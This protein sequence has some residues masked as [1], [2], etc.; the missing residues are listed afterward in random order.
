MNIRKFQQQLK[1]MAAATALSLLATQAIAG[2]LAISDTPLFLTTGVKPNLIM[3]IDDSGS[4]DF[5]V[6]LRGN[7]GAAWWRTGNSSG[8]CSSVT[9]NSFIG[10]IGDG[11]TDIEAAGQLNFNNKG[12]A[13]DTWK[14]FAYL[15]PNGSGGDTSDRRRNG[16]ATN[17]H[18]AIPPLG[19]FAWSRSPEYNRAYFD[20][21]ITYSRW[22]DGGGFTFTN[23]DPTAARFDPVFTGAGTLDLTQDVAGNGNV[24]LDAA[25]ADATM[26]GNAGNHYFKVFQGMTLPEGTC[27]YP[28]TYLDASNTTRNFNSSYQHWQVVSASGCVVGETDKCVAYINGAATTT[29]YTLNTNALVAIRYFPATF[30]LST[31]DAPEAFGYASTTVPDGKAPDGSTMY[32]YEIK[33]GNFVDTE[34]YTAALQNFANW[35]SYYRKRHQA[36]R[37]GLGSAFATLTGTR[38]AGFTIN[39]TRS[40]GSPDVT[41]GDIDVAANRTALY[42]NFYQNWVHSGGT[43]N[44]P[45]VANLIRNYQRTGAGAPIINSCQRNFG[46]LFT[47]GFSNPPSSGDG[48]KGGGG[49]VGN[50]DGSMADPY[51][52]SVDNT[53]ADGVM[54]GYASSLRP[55]LTQGKVT[56]PTACKDANHDPRL[57]CNT[58]PHMNFY[59]ITLGAKGLQFNPD[60]VPAQDPYANPPTWPTSFPQRHPSA[61]DD[62]WHATINGRGQLLNAKSSAELADK[63][64]A[65]LRSIADAVG[66]A[67][68][69]SVNSGS[70]NSDTRLFQASFDSRDWSGKLEAFQ[71]L[72]NGTLGAVTQATIP[73]AGRR[74]IITMNSDGRTVPFLWDRLDP[75]RQA[76]LDATATATSGADLVNYLRGDQSKET[77]AGGPYRARKTTVLG[78]IVNSSP[79]F[80]GAQNFRYP[81]TLEAAKYTDFRRTKLAR[82]H[83]VYVGANDG[84]LHAF[85]SDDATTTADG[86]P[87]NDRPVTETFAY[88]PSVVL[89]NMKALSDPSYTHRF[90]VDGTPTTGDA[91]VGNQW[92][93]MLAAGLNKGGQAIYALDITDA[94]AITETGANSVLHW[95]FTDASDPDHD[96]GFTYSRPQIVRLKTGKW[97]AIFGNGYNNTFADGAAS[98]TGNAVLYIVDLETGSLIRKID[99][100]AGTA[101]DPAGQG[102]PNGL[103][104]PVIVDDD[105]DSNADFVY[106]GDLFGNLWKFNIASADSSGWKISYGT[107]AAP[108]PIFVA[109]DA[110]GVRQPITSRPN[111]S[112]GPDGHGL[113]VLF[114]TGKY[115]ETG[116]GNVPSPARPQSFYGLI[117]PNTG[118]A[119]QDI[120]D[121][122]SKL[123]Q[124]TIASEVLD[125][126]FASPTGTVKADVRVTSANLLTPDSRGWYIDLVSPRVGFEGEM[127]V[128]DS[129]LRN[130]HVIFTTLIPNSDPCEN[131]GTSWL[132]DMNLFTGSRFAESPIDVNN[133]TKFTETL[134]GVPITGVRSK[135]GIEPKGGMVSSENCDYI[136]FPGTSGGTETRCRN[137]G[138]RGYGRQSWRQSR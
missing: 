46:M 67:A 73:S 99:T 41:M 58:D 39:Q 51:K 23:A 66:S 56:V 14:K 90:Y 53:L 132:M 107:A 89:K 109:K 119:T 65:V 80:V 52:D 106:A 45:A 15:F 44:R 100:K 54:S 4:M 97:A 124:Q 111:V 98:T 101:Q 110:N 43:P 36:L 128:T 76:E 95:E 87:D 121:D 78:D 61:V 2:P 9:G 113:V 120:V 8:N 91:F 47:D 19:D 114:G 115:F 105:G 69:A 33:S 127:Q 92:R 135:V 79:A 22:V 126:S 131:G 134:N 133:D 81:D 29:T 102:R 60:A 74:N 24:A 1:Y 5:E 70:I 11:T 86:Q 130:G 21:A 48:M 20:P 3:A 32:R 94:S 118:D 7:D 31:P 6:L 26:P 30:F 88:V 84:M 55:D 49:S 57:D 40:P 35:F 34:H 83:M 62:L 27:L 10:C 38:V 136:I 63:L 104:T 129:I 59:A 68:S 82:P 112:A 71:V 117:D 108:T 103:S 77:T 42:T 85:S 50:V 93:T 137:P 25:C 18:F 72:S 138:V 17:D 16:D 75:T 96:L 13:T 64:S 12:D 37:A 125:A 122:R 28:Q 123:V 116:D